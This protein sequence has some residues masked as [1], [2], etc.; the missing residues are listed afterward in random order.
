MFQVLRQWVLLDVFLNVPA[1]QVS[2]QVLL[3]HEVQGCLQPTREDRWV[4]TSTPSLRSPLKPHR[5]LDSWYP[6]QLGEAAGCPYVPLCEAGGGR[7]LG[8]EHS[9]PATAATVPQGPQFH[10]RCAGTPQVTLNTSSL[11][12]AALQG[13]Q[14]HHV[15]VTFVTHLPWLTGL[16]SSCNPKAS[17]CSPCHH[18]AHSSSALPAQLWASKAGP[19]AGKRVTKALKL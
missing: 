3:H 6:A 14:P 19:N 5:G 2:F 16:G 18:C 11:V 9:H 10:Q 13:I 17:P 1:R 12:D 8:G 4:T 7:G 15:K